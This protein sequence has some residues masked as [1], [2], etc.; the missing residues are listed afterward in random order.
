VFQKMRDNICKP[1][2]KQRKTLAVP[3]DLPFIQMH[4]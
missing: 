3:V 4:I 2:F 1:F